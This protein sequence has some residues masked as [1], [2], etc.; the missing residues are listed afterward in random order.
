M[1]TRTLCAHKLR[2]HQLRVVI[3]STGAWRDEAWW[4]IDAETKL[5]HVVAG[6]HIALIVATPLILSSSLL[7]A[8]TSN[9]LGDRYEHANGTALLCA[10]V[11]TAISLRIGALILQLQNIRGTPT[12][13]PSQS[14]AERK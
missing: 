9:E 11:G 1:L 10:A 6:I 2:S 8:S 3:G 5:E 13:G 4:L 7:Y 12:S 14:P